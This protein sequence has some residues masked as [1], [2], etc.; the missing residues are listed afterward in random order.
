M[1]FVIRCPE[2]E[3]LREVILNQK[4]EIEAIK[5]DKERFAVSMGLELNRLR[6]QFK[7]IGHGQQQRVENAEDRCKITT[8]KRRARERR[9]SVFT[10]M[11]P[12]E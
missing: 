11:W 9:G 8:P 6:D 1:H 5:M 4:M 12:L 10:G 3:D 7:H 2:I